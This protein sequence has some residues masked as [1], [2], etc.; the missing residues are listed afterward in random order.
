MNHR[1]SKLTFWR[2]FDIQCHPK[3]I[4]GTFFWILLELTTNY[5]FQRFEELFAVHFV[6]SFR[7]TVLNYVAITLDLL[8]FLKTQTNQFIYRLTLQ[9]K[10]LFLLLFLLFTLLW[11]CEKI[12][13]N[14]SI[15]YFYK[16]LQLHRKK[17]LQSTSLMDA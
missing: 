2:S 15:F 5:F 6:A 13:I 3:I 14:F 7:F 9:F 1:D 17:R 16:L 10:D 12:I 11:I 4:D 8:A